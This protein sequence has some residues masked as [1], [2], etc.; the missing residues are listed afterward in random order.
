MG[1]QIYEIGSG[2]Y[3]GYGVPAWCDHPGCKEEIDRGM[4]FACGGEPFSELGCDKYFCS[5][6]RQTE[7][8][9]DEG[10][11]CQ[12]EQDI[13]GGCVCTCVEVC[14]SCA[15]KSKEYPYGFPYK[16][17][18]PT[19]VAHVLKDKSWAEWR[20]NHEHLKRKYKEMLKAQT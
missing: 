3:G 17:E 14:E 1:Y 16:P 6:H 12:H 19:W 15:G 10:N 11:I 18:H 9:D 20:R 8:F 4:A 5:K 7:C 2:R 13:D